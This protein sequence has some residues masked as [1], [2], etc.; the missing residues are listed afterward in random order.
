MLVLAG[1]GRVAFDPRPT[2]GPAD[3]APSDGPTDPSGLVAWYAFDGDLHDALGGPDGSCVSSS[4]C[5][6]VIAGHHGPAIELDG[7]SCVQVV[8]SGALDLPTLTLSIWLRAEALGPNATQ[9]SKR[10]DAGGSF[11]DSWQL[12]IPSSPSASESFT[13]KGSAANEE[14]VS[15]AGAIELGVWQHVAATFDGTTKRLYI[16]GVRV[17]SQPESQALSYDT[18]PMLIGCDDNA[19]LVEH[20]QGA[21][22]DL[23]IFDRALSDAEIAD[24][25]AH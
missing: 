3:A 24:L 16:G 22:D 13:Y 2:T 20:F 10:V 5:P 18:H 14:V 12:E 7:T 8:D 11:Y 1:C 19:T 6:V 17:A 21:L 23:K 9:V 15:A 4:S 25:A